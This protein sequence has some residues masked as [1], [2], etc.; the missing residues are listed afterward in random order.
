MHKYSLLGTYL[1]ATGRNEL[2]IWQ[3]RR[4]SE[5]LTRQVFSKTET[6]DR[7]TPSPLLYMHTGIWSSFEF[8]CLLV[9]GPI[10]WPICLWLEVFCRE[11]CKLEIFS[12]HWRCIRFLSCTYF[13]LTPSKLMSFP[14]PPFSCVFWK[15]PVVLTIVLQCSLLL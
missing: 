5:R 13:P 7:H 4:K 9:P 2:K 14:P 3:Q 6:I 11:F 1:Q 15:N 10:C 12:T 8:C